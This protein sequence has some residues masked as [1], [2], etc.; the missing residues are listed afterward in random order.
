MSYD[1]V[2]QGVRF[3]IAYRLGHSEGINVP[4]RAIQAAAEA[5]VHWL[6]L[7]LLTDTGENRD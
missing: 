1:D 3:A 4:G 5:A 2:V 7:S 6:E